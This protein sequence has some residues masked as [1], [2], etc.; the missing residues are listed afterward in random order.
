MI[1]R[2]DAYFFLFLYC[3]PHWRALPYEKNKRELERDCLKNK[4]DVEKRIKKDVMESKEVKKELPKK[5][6]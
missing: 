1:E 3:I 4:M 5:Y 6:T 2:K